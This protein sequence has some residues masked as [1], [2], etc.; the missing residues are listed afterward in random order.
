[1]AYSKSATPKLKFLKPLLNI[2][3][4]HKKYKSF[5]SVL[6]SIA[7]KLVAKYIRGHS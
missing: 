5:V 3:S 4:C 2:L 7:I 1:M 6:F